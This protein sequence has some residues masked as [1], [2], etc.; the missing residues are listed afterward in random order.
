MMGLYGT[1]GL[2]VVLAATA[3]AAVWLYARRAGRSQDRTAV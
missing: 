2:V 3:L 1:L